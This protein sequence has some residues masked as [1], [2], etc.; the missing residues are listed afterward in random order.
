MKKALSFFL[1]CAIF[2]SSAVKAEVS[3]SFP[4]NAFHSVNEQLQYYSYNYGTINTSTAMKGRR[5]VER[6]KAAKQTSSVKESITDSAVTNLGHQG[7]A[8]LLIMIISG[9]EIVRQEI[10]M[11]KLKKQSLDIS[12]LTDLAGKAADRILLGGS[13]YSSMIG[14]GVLGGISYKPLQV[15]NQLIS[16]Q[17]SRAIFKSLL[18][19]GIVSFITFTGWEMGGQ[20]WTEARE[21]I[22]NEADYEMSERLGPILLG[23]LFSVASNSQ[24]SQDDLRVFKEIVGNMVR[25]LV[26]DN[27]LRNL[28]L[29]NTWRMRIATGGFVTIVS[30]MVG[31]GAAGTALFPGAGTLAGLCFGVVG[32][33]LALLIPDNIK[34]G[35][36]NSFASARNYLGTQRSQTMQLQ[37]KE[38]N[39]QDNNP[40]PLDTASDQRLANARVYLRRMQSYREDA[41]TAQFETLYRNYSRLNVLRGN[42]K[43]ASTSNNSDAIQEIDSKI[44]DTISL[45][46]ENVSSLEIF[47]KTESE[48]LNGLK[49]KAKNASLVALEAEENSK[50][51][52]LSGIVSSILSGL[53]ESS[54]DGQ[55]ITA[56]VILLNKIYFMGF[57][58]SFLGL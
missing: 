2:V 37:L 6:I 50:L 55:T 47:Y 23:S 52:I 51:L 22:Q 32:G 9:I 30:A 49:P 15:I 46:K 24:S 10:E 40:F 33:T 14:A 26:T 18:Q 44:H 39:W 3:P 31:A 21:L 36:T 7:Q 4:N 27:D 42:K 35:I 20:L 1:S 11:S 29:Y 16:S 38:I 45:I 48:K 53:F 54:D 8:L 13:I 19:S 41:V 12:E 25:I 17:N 43:V 56:S 5:L 34:E 58:E 57:K 28:W